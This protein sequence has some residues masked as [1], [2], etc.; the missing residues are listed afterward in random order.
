MEKFKKVYCNKL[1]EIV[2]DVCGSSCKKACDNEYATLVAH[3]GY[4]SSKDLTSYNVH[5]CED[6]FDKTIAFLKG[7]RT[8]DNSWETERDL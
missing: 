1:D 5:L 8:T 6:C 7:I 3:W 2:C 4:D